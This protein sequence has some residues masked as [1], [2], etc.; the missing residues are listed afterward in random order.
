VFTVALVVVIVGSTLSASAV[1][2]SAGSTAT[3][4]LT[5]AAIQ[6]DNSTDTSTAG[7]S[8]TNTPTATPASQCDGQPRMSSID[9]VSVDSKIT[10]EQAGT[11]EANFRVD[12][13]SPAD[14]DIIVDIEYRLMDDG[15]QFVGGADWQQSASTI[16]ATQFTL[17]SGE[18]RSISAQILPNGAEVGDEVTIV[19]DLELWYEGNRED[20]RQIK[21]VRSTLTVTDETA[22]PSPS[23]TPTPQQNGDDSDNQQDNQATT[24]SGGGGGGGSGSSITENPF[25]LIS[26]VAV[27]G[28]IIV[29]IIAAR[30]GTD[31]IAFGK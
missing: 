26:L 14:C 31:I 24:S 21:G 20:S 11:V 17:G 23:P 4:G 13:N 9:V 15:F 29:A 7:N 3:S 8:P 22:T 12:P 10:P 30:G 5:H 1:A 19:A 18:I 25:L 28:V 2:A 16:V 27:V 6:P